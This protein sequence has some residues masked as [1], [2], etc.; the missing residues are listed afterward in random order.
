GKGIFVGDEQV[1][2]KEVKKK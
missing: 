2:R 1:K